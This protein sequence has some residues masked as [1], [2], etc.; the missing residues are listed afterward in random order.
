MSRKAQEI[1]EKRSS[2]RRSMDGWVEVRGHRKR[3]SF[4]ARVKDIGSM[5]IGLY[6]KELLPSGT[7]IS[8]SLYFLWKGRSTRVTGLKGW[9]VWSFKNKGDFMFGVRFQK[10]ITRVTYPDLFEFLEEAKRPSHHQEEQWVLGEK[11]DH[12]AQSPSP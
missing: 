3:K 7:M 5:G 6:S 12:H 1:K 8:F 9:V 2:I 4:V 11:G 10:Q